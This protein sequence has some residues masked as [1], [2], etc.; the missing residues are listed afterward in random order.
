MALKR[1]RASGPDEL[2]PA[3]FKD[4]GDALADCL[5]NLFRAVWAN[6]CVPADCLQMPQHS[7]GWVHWGNGW[8]RPSLFT[9]RNAL[10]WRAAMRPLLGKSYPLPSRGGVL[11]KV[12]GRKA[13]IRR[14]KTG[15]TDH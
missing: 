6:E 4:G 5:T 8:S 12:E 7:R 11:T 13:N 14:L 3:L 10:I 15:L 1:Y 2:P 9:S